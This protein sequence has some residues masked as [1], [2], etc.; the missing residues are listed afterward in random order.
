[1]VTARRPCW[2]AVRSQRATANRWCERP[3]M[4]VLASGGLFSDSAAAGTA[5]SC[6]LAGLTVRGAP[7]NHSLQRTAPACFHVER[8][9]GSAP[10]G[11]AAER[12]E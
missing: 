8:Q 2:L 6:A 10:L 1:M 5:T 12:A 3:G 7:P 11:T 9:W 4:S